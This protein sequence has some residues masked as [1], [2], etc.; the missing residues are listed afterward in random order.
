MDNLHDIKFS[1]D[2]LTLAVGGG[3]PAQAGIIEVY[4]WPQFEVIK[5]LEGHDDSVRSVAWFDRNKLFSGSIDRSIKLHTTDGKGASEHL[6]LFLGHSRSVNAICLL[7]GEKTLVSGGLDQSIRVWD[8]ESG[9]LV[10]SMSQH[11]QGIN[12]LALR[13]GAAALPMVASAAADR[14]LRF[15]QPTIGRMVRY[16]RLQSKPLSIA[17]LNDNRSIAAACED[18]KVRIVDANE[19][20][21]LQTIVAFDGWAYPI[22]VHPNDGSLA[23]GGSNDAIK[24][25]QLKI[26]WSQNAKPMTICSNEL[27]F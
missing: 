13:P 19:V 15:W 5:K 8:I 20:K 27:E 14:T 22:A 3:S 7:D 1:P 18:G 2:G 4:S 24:R 6:K 16:I 21:L 10:R 9:K 11:T 25:L 26:S 12:S 23:V 17:W